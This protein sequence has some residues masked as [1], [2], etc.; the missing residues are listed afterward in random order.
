MTGVLLSHPHTALFAQHVGAGLSQAGLL[1]AFVSGLGV[2][3]GAVP[4]SV[5][6]VLAHRAPLVMN[7][8]VPR[9][10]RLVPL[11]MPELMSRVGPRFRREPAPGWQ[12]YD[13]M[14]TAHDRLVASLPWGNPSAVM[15]YEDGALHTFQR[16]AREGLPR[17]YDLPIPYH[18]ML[19]D[20]REH[21]SARWPG[22]QN[23][24]AFGEPPW[25]VARKEAELNL[26]QLVLCASAFTRESLLLHPGPA[27]RT[28]VV[29]YGF[30]VDE[31]T[32]RTREPDGRFTVLAVGTQDLRKGTPYLLHAWKNARLT[33]ARLRIVGQIRLEKAWVEA[34]GVDVEHVPALP[35]ARLQEEFAQADL[36][37]FPT[38][39]DGFGLVMQEAMACGTPVLT[40]RCGGGPECI[41]NGVDGLLVKEADVDA[42]TQ[43]LRDAAADRGALFRM[44]QAA[45]ERAERWSWLDYERTVG[46]TL[47]AFLGSQVP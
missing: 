43:A 26:A 17:I 7:R 25:K 34:L 3:R 14:F 11:S 6:R 32:P 39:G 24:T 22:A 23:L 2:P 10:R 15:A 1:H 30:P 46:E 37:A 40:T 28:A 8:L 18:R 16:A 42:L 5:E 4:T 27:P 20:L 33:Q 19:R 36:L 9:L 31:F 47:R 13:V 21:E 12:W 38:L 45:R 41:T 35:R 29:P 44:G